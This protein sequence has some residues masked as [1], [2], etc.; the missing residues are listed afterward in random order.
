MKQELSVTFL[1]VIALVVA[2]FG[3]VSIIHMWACMI[4]TTALLYRMKTD[5][6]LRSKERTLNDF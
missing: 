1:V 2:Y 3:A 6:V 5:D 4:E